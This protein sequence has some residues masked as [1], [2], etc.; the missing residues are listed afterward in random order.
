MTA[1]LSTMEM[2]AWT[3]CNYRRQQRQTTGKQ[4]GGK[5]TVSDQEQQDGT[6]KKSRRE[7]DEREEQEEKRQ[8]GER[9]PYWLRTSQETRR[10]RWVTL[11]NQEAGLHS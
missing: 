10:T 6:K 1:S 11:C 8:R 3:T 5:N 9:A 2:S 4:H 7:K